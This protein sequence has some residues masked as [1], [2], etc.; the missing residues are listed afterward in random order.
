MALFHAIVVVD[1]PPLRP[2]TPIDTS[3]LRSEDINRPHPQFPEDVQPRYVSI[4]PHGNPNQL[5]KD[6]LRWCFP[7]LDV[8]LRSPYHYESTVDEY[9]FTL[10]QTKAPHRL[11]GFCRRY[12]VGTNA[13]GG[14]SDLP[15]YTN[16]NL[17]EAQAS[18]SFQCIC[19]LSD[20]YVISLLIFI[21]LLFNL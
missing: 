4:Y 7:D 9:V 5:H 16:S 13:V 3:K 8:L 14:R 12:R 19:I 11:H 1:L 15:P 10:T 20:K 18:P 17:E 21:Q 2:V 6:L